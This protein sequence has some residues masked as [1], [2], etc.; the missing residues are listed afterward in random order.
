[1]GY[2]PSEINI[3]VWYKDIREQQKAAPTRSKQGR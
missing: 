1:M 2:K 3:N